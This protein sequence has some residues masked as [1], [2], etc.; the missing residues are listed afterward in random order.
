MDSATHQKAQEEVRLLI[1]KMNQAWLKGN[2]EELR[3]YFH[4]DVAV[5]GPRFE[6]VAT[7]K[8]AC[9]NSYADFVRAAKIQDFKES[10]IRV[11]PFGSAAVATF[12][13]EITYEMN[14]QDYHET[15]HDV[16]VFARRDGKWRAIWRAVL[17]AAA[18]P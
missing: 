17:V 18:A 10:D 8:E 4:D 1:S 15:G 2:L 11:D 3:E 6:S 5:K 7:G 14:G 9:V 16:F 12:A 13:W